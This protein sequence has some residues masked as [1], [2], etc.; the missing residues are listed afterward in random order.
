MLGTLRIG[1]KLLLAPAVVLALLLMLA[2]LAWHGM[3]RQQASLE[4]IVQVRAARLAAAAAVAGALKHAHADAWQLLASTNGSFAK[5]RLA[6]LR[7]GMARR[8]VQVDGALAALAHFAESSEQA[9][10][11]ASTVALAA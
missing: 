10:V 9:I 3:Q 1:P 6:A 11:A 5:A 8:D 4:H 2:A 7:A